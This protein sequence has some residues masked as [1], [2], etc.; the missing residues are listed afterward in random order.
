VAENLGTGKI[1][2][3]R[4]I[5]EWYA[6]E[7]ARIRILN[8]QW[9]QE[10][11]SV[12]VRAHKAW[13]IRH[14]SRQRARTM[15]GMQ[16]QIQLLQKRDLAKYGNPEGPTFDSLVENNEKLGLVGDDIYEAIIVSSMKANIGVNKRLRLK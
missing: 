3:N 10:G 8:D 7:V 16:R 12:Q 5:R 2:T 6:E 9:I 11:L 13:E 15:M 1:K 4:E 14:A